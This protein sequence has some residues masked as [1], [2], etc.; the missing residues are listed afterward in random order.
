MC[1]VLCDSRRCPD[2]QDTARRR[3]AFYEMRLGGARWREV[4]RG[5]ARWRE[6][7]RGGARWREAARGGARWREVARGLLRD[8][9]R[10]A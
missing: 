10:D 6:V 8:A 3:E 4:A 9:P 1:G 7:A 2:A 5:G